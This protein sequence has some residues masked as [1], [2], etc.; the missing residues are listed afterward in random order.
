MVILAVRTPIESPR[1]PK[2]PKMPVLTDFPAKK[3]SLLG[4]FWATF[5]ALFFC[6]SL[7]DTKKGGLGRPSKLD[8][9]FGR[10]WC[11]PG[12]PQE[13]SRLDG[14]SISTFAAGPKKGSK[15]GAKME[16][17]GL[18]NPN[19]T[20]FGAPFGRNWGPKSC[21]QKRVQNLGGRGAGGS[22]ANGALVPLKD[23]AEHPE[24]SRLMIEI[25]A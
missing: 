10:F 20:H 15:M 24:P 23:N 16:P 2:V 11:L 7:R 13:G 21:I 3:P 25:V 17:F 19:Y 12:E 22:M 9:F 18:P 8:P 4:G 14:S 6:S 5:S 1:G